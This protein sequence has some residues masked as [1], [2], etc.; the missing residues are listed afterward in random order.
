M[1]HLL[2]CHLVLDLYRLIVDFLFLPPLLMLL[3][4]KKESKKD[5]KTESKMSQSSAEDETL[6]LVKGNAT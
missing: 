6:N 4:G 1:L 3:D 5:A 2:Y